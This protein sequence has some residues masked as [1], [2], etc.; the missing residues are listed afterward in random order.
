VRAVGSP[1]LQI[2]W[3]RLRLR[4][5]PE[6]LLDK[7]T[8]QSTDGCVL[9]KCFDLEFIPVLYWYSDSD[10][11]LLWLFDFGVIGTPAYPQKGSDA[12]AMAIRTPCGPEGCEACG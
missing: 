5:L 3:L 8:D 2:R 9:L 10:S 6:A 7:G 11:C 12:T 4:L 1:T